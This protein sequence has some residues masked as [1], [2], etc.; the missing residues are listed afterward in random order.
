MKLDEIVAWYQKKIGTYDKQQWE[1]TVEQRILDGFSSVTLKTAKLKTELIDVDLVRGST[2]PKAKPKESFLT[3]IRLAFLRY[4]FLPL[5]AQWWVKQTSPNIFGVLLVLYITQMIT[6]AVYA[7]NINRTNQEGVS[8]TGIVYSLSAKNLTVSQNGEV[9][10]KQSEEH[11]VS[12]AEL[13]IPMTLSFLLSLVHSQIVATTTATNNNKNKR[14]RFSNSNVNGKL[15]RD[16]RLRRR[17][18]LVK[19]SF[20]EAASQQRKP[21]TIAKKPHSSEEI[22]AKILSNTTIDKTG[23]S[24]YATKIYKISNS[25]TYYGFP[26]SKENFN[27][28]ADINLNATVNAFPTLR[29]D[30]KGMVDDKSASCSTDCSSTDTQ[31]SISNKKRN[32]NW[33]NPL[34]NFKKETHE[35]QQQTSPQTGSSTTTS[36]T[37]SPNNWEAN[38]PINSSLPN[39][40]CMRKNNSSPNKTVRIDDN[41]E[42]I[43]GSVH[44]VREIAGE[45][46]RNVEALEN[47]SNIRRAIGEDD[48]FESLNG[49]SSSGEET[50]SP[51]PST[52]SACVPNLLRLRASTG[53]F[54]KQLDAQ[55]KKTLPYPI[56]SHIM[57]GVDLAKRI[58]SVINEEP[59]KFSNL[60]FNRRT[61]ESSCDT[62]EEGDDGETISS[63][64][65]LCNNS[66][67]NECTTSAT[68]WLGVTTNSEDCSYSS[69]INNLD[70]YKNQQISDDN[71]YDADFTPTT[72]L[73]PHS[74]TD[75]ISCTVWDQREIKKAQMSVLEISSC[76]IARV[77]SMPETNDYIYIG[78]FFSFILSLIP[79]FCRLCEIGINSEETTEINYLDIPILLWEKSSSS[80]YTILLFAFGQTNWERTILVIAFIQRLILSMVLFIIFSVAER[81]F[82]QRFLY[83]KLFSHITSSRRARKSNIPHFRLNKVRNIKTWLSVRSYLKKRGPQR[84]IDI[85]VSAAFLVTLL[86]LSFLSVEW[87]KDSVHLHSHLNL[88][89]LLWSVTIGVF[90]LRFMT[91]GNKIHDK[92]RSVSVL[93]T[94][95]IN[96]YLQIEQKPKKKDELMVSN[97]VLKL[98]ADLL[99]ELETP[100]KISGLSANPYL[101]T[102]I[103][104]VILSALS[105]VL[106][107][108]LGFKLKLHKIKIK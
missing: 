108:M 53:D 38:I 29:L 61:D 65:S 90:L 57:S 86:L 9:P 28:L 18:K 75:R 47:N 64:N 102:T 69:D 10:E 46:V 87:L 85:I 6:W 83:A 72:I 58:S 106:S 23:D 99:K 89:A 15:S 16:T 107:E 79:I 97:S 51:L 24:N 94:E 95:Q 40:C 67:Y 105:G 30:L 73:N 2:F 22:S 33:H 93:I 17:K 63:P 34:E 71:G 41:V 25:R 52:S 66:N 49:K 76:I 78:I 101:F 56:K 70:D 77:E 50:N 12:L 104:V 32:V 3:V 100:F 37:N 14:R 42:I 1:N 84:S 68:E 80:I 55:P 48:G 91:L 103:K 19:N 35:K 98:A 82:K 4:F 81:T 74:T 26:T 39:S 11:I 92:Y 5:Y 62:D 59:I 20:V 45:E 31:L 36:E 21:L 44:E 13:L 43:D 60:K 54:L 8:V 88:E 7:L 27:N 96:L